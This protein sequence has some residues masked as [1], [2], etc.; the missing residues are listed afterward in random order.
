MPWKLVQPEETPDEQQ[1]RLRSMSEDDG[2]TWDL[3]DNDKAACAAGADALARVA[4]L[5]A[6]LGKVRDCDNDHACDIC[7][8]IAR[9]ALG[10]TQDTPGGRQ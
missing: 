4:A 2:D 7:R 1:G 6:A 9:E 5:E 3:S 8:D 10:V